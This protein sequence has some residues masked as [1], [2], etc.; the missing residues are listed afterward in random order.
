MLV[1]ELLQLFPFQ[2]P[3]P[4]A[5]FFVEDLRE[6]EIQSNELPNKCRPI[7]EQGF[8]HQLLSTVQ[9]IQSTRKSFAREN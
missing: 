4:V 3:C 7:E 2:S 9:L 1:V 6:I 8:E 5:M